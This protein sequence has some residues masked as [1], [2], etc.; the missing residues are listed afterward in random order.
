MPNSNNNDVLEG[1]L[2]NSV[3]YLEKDDEEKLTH[4]SHAIGIQSREDE[5]GVD[6]VQIQG[7]GG[8]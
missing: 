8:R 5:Y 6:G 7:R 1:H 3:E 4:I 2:P